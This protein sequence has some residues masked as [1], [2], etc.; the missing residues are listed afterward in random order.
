[1]SRALGDFLPPCRS[2]FGV[3]FEDPLGFLLACL[4]VPLG[5]LNCCKAHN[6]RQVRPLVKICVLLM[7]IKNTLMK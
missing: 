4:A 1:M 6:D 2:T 3:M 7:H 5:A